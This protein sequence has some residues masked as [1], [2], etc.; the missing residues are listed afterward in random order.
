MKKELTIALILMLILAPIILAQDQKKQISEDEAMNYYCTTWVNPAYFGSNS[1]TGIKIM[2][3]DGTWE[4]YSSE[5]TPWPTWLGSFRIEKSWK[6]KDGN[7]WLNITYR[8][9]KWSKY[10]VAKI[11][12][13]GNTLEQVYSMSDYPTAVDPKDATYFIMKK[14]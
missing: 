5:R 10:V 8:E 13:A 9:A 12:D 11:S 6:D 14:K 3:R 1:Y 2:K 7:L 4:W